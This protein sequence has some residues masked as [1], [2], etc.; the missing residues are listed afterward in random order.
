MVGLMANDV[1][2]WSSSS[3]ASVLGIASPQPGAAPAPSNSGAVGRATHGRPRRAA[4]GR[5][6]RAQRGGGALG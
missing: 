4:G 2:R 3:S 6:G 1:F 5:A